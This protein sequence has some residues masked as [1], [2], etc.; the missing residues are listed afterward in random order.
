MVLLRFFFI[1]IRFFPSRSVEL[2]RLKNGTDSNLLRQARSIFIVL[3]YRLIRSVAKPA[4]KSTV[5]KI[6]ALQKWNGK[7]VVRHRVSRVE[8]A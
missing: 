1:I 4:K 7:R 2:D 8:L 6:R 5:I 3:Y